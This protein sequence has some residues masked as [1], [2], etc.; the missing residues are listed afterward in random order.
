[1][2]FAVGDIESEMIWVYGLSLFDLAPTHV[3]VPELRE[4]EVEGPGSPGGGP[5]GGPLS[6]LSGGLVM[7]PMAAAIG[8]Y[9]KTS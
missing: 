7:V 3:G 1:M 4:V 5:G 8:P 6:L 9:L 2:M